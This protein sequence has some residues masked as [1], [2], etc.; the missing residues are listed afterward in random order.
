M[1]L[2]KR[3]IQRNWQ[4][5]IHKTQ[6]IYMLEN[7][8][9]D[10]MLPVSLDCS[11]SLPLRYSLTCICPVSCVS[12]VSSFSGLF[13]FMTPSIFSNMHLSCVLCILSCQFLWI[14][15]SQDTGHIHVR[16]YRRGNEKGQSRE[17]GNIGYTRHRTNT[18]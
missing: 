4:H 18:C 11:F 17:T 1:G 15:L 12:Y 13:F 8:E 3:T 9:G 7:T 10:P 14:V 2:C 5:R 16:E 6:D